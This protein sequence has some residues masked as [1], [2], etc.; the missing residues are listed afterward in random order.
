MGGD[1]GQNTTELLIRLPDDI[2]WYFTRTRVVGKLSH[3]TYKEE[4]GSCCADIVCSFLVTFTRPS[5]FSTKTNFCNDFCCSQIAGYYS[6]W[7]CWVTL[8]WPNLGTKGW[9]L[10]AET[11]QIMDEAEKGFGT[12]SRI[13]FDFNRQVFKCVIYVKLDHSFE[14]VIL[15][16]YQPVGSFHDKHLLR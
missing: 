9:S 12:R 4:V 15:F 7:K 3:V 8:R 5:S 11:S 16:L 10:L 6:S 2:E 1:A 13:R 14:I